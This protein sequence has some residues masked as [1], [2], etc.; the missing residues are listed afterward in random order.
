MENLTGSSRA[1]TL[2]G[3]AGGNRIDGGAGD[4]RLVGGDGADTLIGGSGID[5]ADYSGAGAGVTMNLASGGSGSAG[6]AAGDSL[7]GI[8][9]IIGS[10]F[11]DDLTLSLGNGWSVDAGGGNDVVHLAAGSGTVSEANLAGV[12]S[13]VETIDFT[14]AGTNGN[15][16]VDAG[17]IQSLVGNG[18]SSHLTLDFDAGD[19]VSVANGSFYNQAGNEYTFYS[20]ATM[21]T[22]V[23][24]LT[25]V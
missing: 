14:S 10:G 25:L 15:L 8:E 2:I 16:A 13:H 20:D 6:D 3:D 1:D 7:S 11:G 12:L 19:T 21:T 17:F 24:K 22:E 5:T 4:D 18:A 9:R 23:A